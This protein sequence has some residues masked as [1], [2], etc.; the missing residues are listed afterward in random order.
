[1]SDAI[2]CDRCGTTKSRDGLVGWTHTEEVG[3][4]TRSFGSGSREH[5]FCSPACV[6]AF[7]HPDQLAR[8]V[9]G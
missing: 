5:D 9:G 3:I 7:F 6:S 8:I 2:K 1:M 4:D